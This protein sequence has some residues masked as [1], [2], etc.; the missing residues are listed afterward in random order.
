MLRASLKPSSYRKVDEA[1]VNLFF[2]KKNE[3]VNDFKML[4]QHYEKTKRYT[5]R[6]Y[7]GDHVLNMLAVYPKSSGATSGML[8]IVLP[9]HL[10]VVV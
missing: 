1:T 8:S 7:I 3:Q 2:L 10:L 5:P 9:F 4:K 6:T